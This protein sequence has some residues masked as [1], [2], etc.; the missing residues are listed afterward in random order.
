VCQEYGY[1]FGTWP[2]I[3]RPAKFSRPSHD[4]G[5]L[6]NRH[7]LLL[8]SEC[9]ACFY[10]YAKKW[11]WRWMCVCVCVRACVRACVCVIDPEAGWQEEAQRGKPPDHAAQRQEQVTTTRPTADNTP[12]PSRLVDPR[13]WPV[14]PMTCCHQ[15][16]VYITSHV[17]QTEAGLA[18]SVYEK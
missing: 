18:A 1:I 4:L 5:G 11:W 3:G 16:A 10:F 17:V 15:T 12:D 13:R 6:W 8:L 14:W 2:Q 9:P 7:C